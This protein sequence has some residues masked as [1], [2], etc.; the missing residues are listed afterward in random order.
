MHFLRFFTLTIAFI[1]IPLAVQAQG[2]CAQEPINMREIGEADRYCSVYDRQLAYREERI[3]FRKMIEERREDFIAPQLEAEKK[4]EK[5]LEALHE[6]R[7]HDDDIY[8]R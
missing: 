1:I 8:G 3:K 4:Y 7:N 2:Y 5:D 6:R